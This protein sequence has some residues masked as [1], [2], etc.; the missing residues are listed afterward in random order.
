MIFNPKNQILLWPKAKI[1]EMGIY[2]NNQTKSHLRGSSMGTQ[3]LLITAKKI[4]ANQQNSMYALTPT[5]RS[6]PQAA[7]EIMYNIMPLDL[8]LIEIGLKTYL[9]LKQQLDTPK[10]TT[11][12]QGHL[13][14]WDSL[15]TN[16]KPLWQ[17]D[18]T[19]NEAQWFKQYQNNMNSL[20]GQQKHKT[21]SEITVYTD[22][23]KT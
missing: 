12:I 5:T 23:S 16:A 10:D 6:T 18:D 17:A 22:G 14:Y 2:R 21:P 13:S 1:D 9:R 11:H 7:L 8:H 15:Q 3:S 20:D 4:K 19:C